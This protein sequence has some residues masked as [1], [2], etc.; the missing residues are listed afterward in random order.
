M[1][2][3]MITGIQIRA[4]RSALRWTAEDL[5]SRA[6]I[7][8]RT[9]KRM[10]SY[11]SVPKSSSQTLEKMRKAFEVAGIEFTGTPENFPGVCMNLAKM[12]A[13]TS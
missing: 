11:D 10:E 4:A 8:S 12:K 1:W 3:S 2:W 9:V 7:A 6:E 5:A 13:T